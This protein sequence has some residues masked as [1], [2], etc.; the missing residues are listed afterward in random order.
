MTR[1][2]VADDPSRH[3]ADLLGDRL[4]AGVRHVALSGGRTPRDAYALVGE[5]GVGEVEW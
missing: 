4:A 3:L 1:L 2:T 5:R